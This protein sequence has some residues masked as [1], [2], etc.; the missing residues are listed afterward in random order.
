MTSHDFTPYPDPATQPDP[1]LEF[2]KMAEQLT[3]DI[4]NYTFMHH[5]IR[6]WGLHY[7]TENPGASAG[8]ILDLLLTDPR[9]KK[10]ANHMGVTLA[11]MR[12]HI[13]EQAKLMF[14]H[15]ALSILWSP[16]TWESR[17]P[18]TEELHMHDCTGMAYMFPGPCDDTCIQT[19]WAQHVCHNLN[20]TCS[21]PVTAYKRSKAK[22]QPLGSS[23]RVSDSVDPDTEYENY[24]PYDPYDDSA[25]SSSDDE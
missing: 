16:R 10:K 7:A 22:M 9:S 15:H 6:S 23:A 13:L 25:E 20:G 12:G 14:Q 18:G 1:S 3:T 24:D 8:M 19:R 2:A 5:A 4:E 17:V 11:R 21:C